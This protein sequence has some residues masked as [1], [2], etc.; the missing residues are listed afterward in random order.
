MAILLVALGISLLP[1]LYLLALGV[2]RLLRWYLDYLDRRDYAAFR[3]ELLR[4]E[5]QLW[6][7]RGR[8]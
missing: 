4:A 5:A 2:L 8:A 3:A 7:K 1:V 6:T